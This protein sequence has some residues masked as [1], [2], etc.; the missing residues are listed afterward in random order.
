M[1]S[2]ISAQPGPLVAWGDNSAGEATVPTGLFKQVA[3]GT[4]HSIA[5][6]SD[7][8]AIA[9]GS[10]TNGQLNAG[11]RAA[12]YVA[13]G[14]A[15]SVIIKPDGTLVGSG[16]GGAV[17]D[18]TFVAVDLGNVHGVG[19]T[20]S[21]AAVA[22]GSNTYGQCDVPSGLESGVTA[23]AAGYAHSL[24]LKNGIVYAWGRNENGVNPTFQCNVPAGLSN[25]I[26]ISAQTDTS[27]ALT[28][29][30]TVWCWGDGF[31][32]ENLGGGWV[33]EPKAYTS[34]G[35]VGIA[36]TAC[37]CFS[38]TAQG[39]VR[40]HNPEWADVALTVP[41]GLL[42]HAVCASQVAWTGHVIAIIGETKFMADVVSGDFPLAVQFTDQSTTFPT[43]W[44]WDFGDGSDHATTQ[45]P[46]H[47]YEAAGT[48]TVTQV[49]QTPVGAQTVTKAN[50][51][52]VIAPPPTAAF[53]ASEARG[54]VPFEVTF[55]NNSTSTS[56]VTYRW[57]FGD[58]STSTEESPTHIYTRPGLYVV[59]LAATNLGGTAIRLANVF[60]IEDNPIGGIYKQSYSYDPPVEYPGLVG[61]VASDLRV[62]FHS[63]EYTPTFFAV[64]SDNSVTAWEH[65][66]DAYDPEYTDTPIALPEGLRVLSIESRR[67]YGLAV[68]LTGGV[69]GWGTNTN[70]VLNIPA[71]LV[72][73]VEIRAVSV[74]AG[75]G[76]SLA[77]L[78]DGSLKI[79]GN[80]YNI[81]NSIKNRPSLRVVAAVASTYAVVTLDH[82]GVVTT[83]SGATTTTRDIG[84]VSISSGLDAMVAMCENGDVVVLRGIYDIAEGTLFEA[85]AVSVAG[86][87]NNFAVIRR[88][89]TAAVIAGSK[90]IPLPEGGRIR[91]I[92][93]GLANVGV[94]GE[95]PPLPSIDQSAVIGNSPLVVQFAGSGVWRPTSWLWDF[96]DGGTSADQ[97]PVHTFTTQGT[98]N[99]TLT[100]SNEL[101]GR[102]TRSSVICVSEGMCV[103]WVP[104][105]VTSAWVPFEGIG[106]IVKLVPSCY[107]VYA[108]A[109]DG[110]VFQPGYPEPVVD[111]SGNVIIATDVV[112]AGHHGV[113][114]LRENGSVVMNG[115]NGYGECDVPDGL[116]AVSIG[117]GTYHSIA[118]REDGSIVQWGQGRGDVPANIVGRKAVSV[119][120]GNQFTVALFDDGS[121]AMWY[122]EDLDPYTATFLFE[123][124]PMKRV[125]ANG[126]D[127]VCI[128]ELGELYHVG[129]DDDS[130]LPEDL[131][132]IFA[133]LDVIDVG[134]R[135]DWAGMSIVCHLS[136]GRIC[137]YSVEVPAW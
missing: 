57:N 82:N 33:H 93:T 122:I 113:M 81:P 38:Y 137:T 132:D 42:A 52:T 50:Y 71:E 72:D 75:A 61:I 129:K 136:D 56:P 4:A 123:G 44:D 121:V 105:D 80:S 88:D 79:W 37:G 117:S 96:G 13:A 109:T 9:W 69:V 91:V 74:S 70:G 54:D 12:I 134:W 62:G 68:T 112:A 7:G 60:A 116:R 1:K 63:N 101:G 107:E 98:H 86:G 87:N 32:Y 118:I 77:L 108:L 10:N 115:D 25:V 84:A 133:G 92:S 35:A 31:C 6:R 94:L 47:V 23:V 58:G 41:G 59:S 8:T 85:D 20:E 11:N 24:A 30:G 99:V 76:I 128:S 3:C 97:N 43:A 14:P 83:W 135:S 55:A 40:A 78:E 120:G 26:A 22:W 127:I 17:P 39:A 27:A 90:Q 125:V 67:G 104:G 102:F 110:R 89:N 36:A 66:H 106:E 119:A 51:I 53:V 15:S 130:V 95:F 48:Y 100:A 114:A 45:H 18:G 28:A 124:I 103:G 49:V 126:S 5:L 131:G 64:H 111:G 2:T 19:I 29:D 73:P 34:I 16:I 46:L 21:G 65:H